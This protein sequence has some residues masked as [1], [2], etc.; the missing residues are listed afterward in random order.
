VKGLVMKN[1]IYLTLILFLGVMGYF[2]VNTLF[3]ESNFILAGVVFLVIS[4]VI[5]LLTTHYKKR[6]ELQ[7]AQKIINFVYISIFAIYGVVAGL[8]LMYAPVYEFSIAS[9]G[10]ILFLVSSFILL[11][12]LYV[13]MKRS[14]L[15]GM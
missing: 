7:P 1:G 8:S 12:G 10:G 11:V 2:V 5:A 9:M 14:V 15:R 6:R 3:N 4:V 13:F